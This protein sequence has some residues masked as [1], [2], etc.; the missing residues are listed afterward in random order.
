MK[1]NI[2][3][4]IQLFSILIEYIVIFVFFYF[5][6]KLSLMICIII[7]SILFLIG[8]IIGLIS[9]RS[10]KLDST[11]EK[12]ERPLENDFNDLINKINYEYH[13]KMKLI[14]IDYNNIGGIA[15]SAG[16]NIY[17]NNAYNVNDEY[18]KGIL[19]HEIGH[20]MSGL[21]YYSFLDSMKLS[22]IISKI[23]N[24]LMLLCLNKYLKIF[25]W[26]FFILYTLFS[27]NNLIFTYP[28]LYFDEY[29]ANKNAVKIGLGHNLRCYYAMCYHDE[30]QKI[31]KWADF[32]HPDVRK[33]MD[34]L[35]KEL[36]IKKED[37][38]FYFIDHTLYYTKVDTLTLT[39]PS[40]IEIL[41]NNCI[42]SATLIKIKADNV[43]IIKRKAFNKCL[44]VENL[45]IPK[46]KELDYQAIERLKLKNLKINDKA[47]L[48]NL[49]KLDKGRNEFSKK[50][51]NNLIKQNYFDA[52]EYQK[53][54]ELEG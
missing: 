45:I 10:L 42:E 1:K 18:L 48:L 24:L 30:R 12:E 34:K 43:R 52:V 49:I 23:F 13:L 33:M 46:V 53:E 32:S 4:I 15:F 35:N 8:L 22:T 17:I 16:H 28:F 39:L 44:K 47:L 26:L 11:N 50:E 27:L 2:F 25:S 3:I 31:E 36:Q 14:Y 9:K 41:N 54:L 7:T 5:L 6:L 38:G 20:H 21:C 51:I 37:L 19:A 29:V 40:Y